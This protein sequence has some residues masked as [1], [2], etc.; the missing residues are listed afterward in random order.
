M[1]YAEAALFEVLSGVRAL[2][3][4]NGRPVVVRLA[5]EPLGDPRALAEAFGVEPAFSAGHG[6]FVLHAAT[7][8]TLSMISPDRR[9]LARISNA[10][11]RAARAASSTVAP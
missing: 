10:S 7:K 9:R 2:V 1:S 6:E 11:A 3:G 5:H 8:C 4:P